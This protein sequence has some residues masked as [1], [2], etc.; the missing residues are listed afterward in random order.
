MKVFLFAIFVLFQGV[1]AANGSKKLERQWLAQFG[2]DSQSD[3]FSSEIEMSFIGKKKRIDSYLTFFIQNIDFD[4]NSNANVM[5]NSEVNAALLGAKG[6][7]MFPLISKFGF[8]PHIG[9]GWGRS[10]LDVDPWFGE[11]ESSL[12]RK[13]FFL[14]ETGAFIHFKKF[15][16]KLN[17]K[18]TTLNYLSNS[19]TIS[20]G[21]NFN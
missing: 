6:G 11:R 15:V 1:C 5:N 17:Y 20:L 2:V 12:G 16:T 13:Q 14:I 3:Y 10:N 9:A 4:K 8:A 19:F 7:I 21:V 18:V